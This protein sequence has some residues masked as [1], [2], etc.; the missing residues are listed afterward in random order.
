MGIFGS[1]QLK[2]P[3]CHGPVERDPMDFDVPAEVGW[4][5]LSEIVGALIVLLC[6]WLFHQEMLLAGFFASLALLAW[7]LMRQHAKAQF[8]CRACK[9]S[10]TR[11]EL[12][13]LLRR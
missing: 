9:L 3:M 4:G 1:D 6:A 11:A 12:K 5:C 13:R 8:V 7:W 10:W 2:C